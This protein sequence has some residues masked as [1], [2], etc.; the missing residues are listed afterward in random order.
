MHLIDAAQGISVLPPVLDF[1][2]VLRFFSVKALYNIFW[3]GTSYRCSDTVDDIST[4]HLVT[5][6]IQDMRKCQVLDSHIPRRREYFP[7]HT[8][9][10]SRWF[11]ISRVD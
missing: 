3:R 9:L 1:P 8:S 4:F 6:M 5:D 2:A 11:D 7:A 10:L